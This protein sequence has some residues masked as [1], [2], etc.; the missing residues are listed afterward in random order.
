MSDEPLVFT[1]DQFSGRARVFPLPELVMF[2]HVM[3]ALHVFEP[4]Y[5]RMTEDALGDADPPDLQEAAPIA[6]ATFAGT[7]WR[8]DYAG[9]PPLRPVVCVGRIV[10]HRRLPDGRHDLVLHGVARARILAMH[11]PGGD[12]PYRMAE[13]VPL[14]RP[15]APRPPMPGVRSAFEEMLARPRLGR[16]EGMQQA[17]EWFRRP[18]M[19][20]HAAVEVAGHVLVRDPELRYRMLSEADPVRRASLLRDA[21]AGIERMVA[22]AERQG[23]DAWPRGESWN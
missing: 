17:L 20:T 12:R 23:S 14:E 10:R 13:L 15:H 2:P 8:E 4:R 1:N 16:V 22:L 3:Q 11:E 5:R 18:E 7:S 6:M 19:P 9:T 21:V